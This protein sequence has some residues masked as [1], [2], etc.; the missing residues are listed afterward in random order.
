[1]LTDDEK[2]MHSHKIEVEDVKRYTKANAKDIIAVG[3]DM[4]K[5]FIFN[6][7][8]FVSGAFYENICRMAKRITINQVKGTFGFNDRYALPEPHRCRFYKSLL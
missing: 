7:F 5:T 8:D 2:F 6:D 3:F 4:K 1:M